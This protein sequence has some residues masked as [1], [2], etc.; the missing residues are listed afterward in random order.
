VA[1]DKA[2][3]QITTTLPLTVLNTI[4]DQKLDSIKIASG[5]VT[6]SF[7]RSAIQ[8]FKTTYGEDQTVTD[9]GTNTV[10]VTIPYTLGETRRQVM[11]VQFM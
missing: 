1:T 2:A 10:N 8:H 3:A 6:L 4:L 9:F 5:I 7:D 11:S